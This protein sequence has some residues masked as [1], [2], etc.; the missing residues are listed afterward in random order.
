MTDLMPAIDAA[1]DRIA[2][3]MP[4]D[5][6]GVALRELEPIVVALRTPAGEPLAHPHLVPLPEH[7]LAQFVALLKRTPPEQRYDL[8]VSAGQAFIAKQ[9]QLRSPS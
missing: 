8:L 4:T 3:A 5:Q 6:R 9:K 7:R 2:A 1:R